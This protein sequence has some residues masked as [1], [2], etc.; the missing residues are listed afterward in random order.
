MSFGS[1]TGRTR[2]GTK[3][4]SN[5]EKKQK[6]KKQEF[7]IHRRA[8]F[9]ESERPDPEEVRARTILALDRLGHQVLSSEPGGYDLED[10]TRSLNS[11]LDDFQ[12]K[13]GAG[14][15][16]EE[17]RK[18]RQEVLS[19]L[20]PSSSAR[21][22]ESEIER[23]TKEE[24]AARTAVEDAEK[25]ATAR[26]ASLRDERDA[27]AKEIKAQKDRL[28]ELK[29][30]NQ[31]RQFFSRIL[32][33]GPSTAKAEETLAELESKLSRLEEEIEKSRKARSAGRGGAPGEGDPA[34][35]EAQQRLEA[36]RERLL[37]L[38]ASR[39][40]LLQLADEREAVT[41]ALSQMISALKLDVPAPSDASGGAAV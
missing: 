13:A 16:T 10:W 11:L 6:R 24:D 31:S 30:A 1:G 9:Q 38:Q 40:N 18:R 34:Y 39:Q 17:F 2:S 14:L 3:G 4:F 35:L 19:G 5:K 23:L 21:D 36:T 22:V 32:R 33:A 29:Q 20:A 15:A 7:H 41:Q 37:D 8:H 12:E 25:R 26:L 28:A 27:C